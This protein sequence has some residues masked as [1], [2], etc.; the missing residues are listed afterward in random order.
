MDNRE[1]SKRWPCL[2][3]AKGMQRTA[4]YVVKVARDTRSLLELFVVY[5]P[6][7]M[8]GSK[9]MGAARLV[10]PLVELIRTILVD[11]RNCGSPG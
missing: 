4:Q 2:S 8:M 5:E 9:P 6:L 7:R 11:V 10:K 1:A 3:R